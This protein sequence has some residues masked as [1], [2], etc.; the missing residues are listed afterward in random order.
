MQAVAKQQ[1]VCHCECD[2]SVNIYDREFMCE[3]ITIQ[4][5]FGQKIRRNSGISVAWWRCGRAL[6][7][8]LMISMQVKRFTKSAAPSRSYKQKCSVLATFD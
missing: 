4:H 8:R 3:Y 5:V 6:D 1:V 7:L 2:E